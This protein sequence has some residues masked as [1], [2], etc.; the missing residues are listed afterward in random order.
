MLLFSSIQAHL[1]IFCSVKDFSYKYISIFQEP[2][3][4]LS[5][6]V[7][8]CF[9]REGVKIKPPGI[10]KNNL[11]MISIIVHIKKVTIDLRPK[12]GVVLPNV[13][14]LTAS[15]MNIFFLSLLEHVVNMF[16]NEI[17]RY[18]QLPWVCVYL[19]LL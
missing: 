19:W 7:Q 12:S 10:I 6:M 14:V 15:L 2:L 11:K 5:N 13:F 1:V 8:I 16:T 9:Y 4:I 3:A 17:A 18:I